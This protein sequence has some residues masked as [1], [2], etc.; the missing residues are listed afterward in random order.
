M[1]EVI[2]TEEQLQEK[3]AYWQKILRLSDWIITVRIARERDMNLSGCAGEIS[4]SLNNKA[5]SI[6]ILDEIDCPQDLMYPQDME[7]TLV[8]ELLHLHLA[9]VSECYGKNEDIYSLFEEQAIESIS[10]A[11]VRV[12]RENG[13]RS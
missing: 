12:S 8:H 9:P 6:R 5:A 1:Q 3:L 11:L 4:W 7:K 13:D 10:H 2:L